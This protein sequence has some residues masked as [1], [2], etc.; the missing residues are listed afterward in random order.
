MKIVSYSRL[1]VTVLAGFVAADW[2]FHS[3]PDL[4]PPRLNITVP[5]NPNEVETGYIFIAAYG[6][7]DPGNSGPE[8]PAAYIFR[9]NGD[10]IWSGLGYFAG[11]VANFRPD[12]WHGQPVLRAFQ[13]IFSTTRGRMFGHHVILNN[14]YQAI[15]SVKAPG[16]R[17][18]SAHEFRIVDGKTVL[19]ENPLVV[20]RDLRPWGGKAGQNWIISNGFQGLKAATATVLSGA[21]SKCRN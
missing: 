6:G 7:F 12:V 8:Q 3:R 14:R 17:F 2:Q 20:P 10:L 21:N 15:K 1:L 18:E 16:H 11:W 9:D 5:A 4:S 19:I 13:G